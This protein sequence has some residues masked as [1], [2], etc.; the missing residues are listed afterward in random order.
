MANSGPPAKKI[1]NITSFFTAAT[2]QLPSSAATNP[3]PTKSAVI[4]H[5]NP[6]SL[7]PQAQTHG[8][9]IALAFTEANGV[10]TRN[11]DMQ[12]PD[13]CKRAL[14]TGHAM[15]DAGFKYPF[16]C[17]KTWKVFLSKVHITG[18]NNA[19]KY[20]FKMEGVVCVLCV[21]FSSTEVE[22]DRGKITP[23]GSFVTTPFKKFEKISEG[24]KHHLQNKYHRW[25]FSGACGLDWGGSSFWQRD[26]GG[27]ARKDT[28]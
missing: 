9:D 5:Q 10:W 26:E 24:L 15:P 2:A 6:P 13:A 11:T 4:V 20:S 12:M 18:Q 19:F 27:R 8:L 3:N 16:G 23:L 14:L 7:S 25:S 22:N 28:L 17:K 1:C 21:L